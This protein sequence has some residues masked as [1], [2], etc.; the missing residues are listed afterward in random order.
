MIELL[1]T[2]ANTTDVS[3]NSKKI[4]IANFASFFRISAFFIGYVLFYAI[5]VPV[6]MHFVNKSWNVTGGLVKVLREKGFTTK[7]V[8][9][10]IILSNRS[11]FCLSFGSCTFWS[12]PSV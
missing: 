6:I 7:T 1:N 3:A 11:T 4:H 10:L 5:T 2:T 12:S 9:L 8:S